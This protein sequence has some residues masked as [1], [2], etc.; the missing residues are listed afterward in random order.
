MKYLSTTDVH[1]NKKDALKVSAAIFPLLISGF[2]IPNVVLSKTTF[3]CATKLSC[4]NF[5]KSRSFILFDRIHNVYI[6]WRAGN[7][8]AVY[9]VGNMTA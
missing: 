2:V 3:Y 6:E 4:G 5:W 1:S 8:D 9:L 7:E